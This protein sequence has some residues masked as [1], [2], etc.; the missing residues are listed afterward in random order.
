MHRNAAEKRKS[1]KLSWL[2]YGGLKIHHPCCLFEA[3][4]VPVRTIIFIDEPGA[5]AFAE[6]VLGHEKTGNGQVGFVD[7]GQIF[8]FI[9]L[10]FSVLSALLAYT[11]DLQ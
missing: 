6:I 4:R 8:M 2:T 11:S 1:V 3:F 9:V 5:H 7:L 10:Q